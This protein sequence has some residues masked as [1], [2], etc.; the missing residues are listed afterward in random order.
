MYAGLVVLLSLVCLV[1]GVAIVR[2]TRSSTT[3]HHRS[4]YFLALNLSEPAINTPLIGISFYSQFDI[5]T[6]SHAT[7]WLYPLPMLVLLIPAIG[8]V[9]PDREERKLSAVVLGLGLARMLVVVSIFS[10]LTWDSGEALMGILWF[11]LALLACSGWWGYMQLRRWKRM[12]VS[13]GA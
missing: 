6:S 1:M 8:L 11:G 12:E 3:V 10:G 7:W 9:F 5:N 13:Y 4:R 2:Q